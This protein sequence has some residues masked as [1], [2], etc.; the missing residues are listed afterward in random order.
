MAAP[1]G[2]AGV[3]TSLL[4][5]DPPVAGDDARSCPALHRR[6]SLPR[7]ARHPSQRP[8]P[9]TDPHLGCVERA[10]LH[11]YRSYRPRFVAEFGFQ[12]PANH[13]TLAR[14]VSARPLY[15]DDASWL[16]TRRP[17]TAWLLLDRASRRTP[18]SRADFDRWHYL[19]QLNQASALRTGVGH[20]RSLHERCSGVIWWQLNDCWPALSWSVVDGDG[21]R[22]LAWYAA[23]AAFC[24]PQLWSSPRKAE[25]AGRLR[26]LNDTR[27]P[28]W[29][30]SPR[31]G[32]GSTEQ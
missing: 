12:A 8:E 9:R 30:R 3:G 4:S 24:Q 1:S 13:A 22:K 25:M 32:S 2:R 23:R 31:C 6:E 26:R 19:T 20:F 10:G 21:R 15:P 14:A 11:H 5:T 18:E 17:S 29:G 16:T 27:N 28:G 7:A